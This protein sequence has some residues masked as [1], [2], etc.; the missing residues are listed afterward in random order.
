MIPEVNLKDDLGK[1]KTTVHL[2]DKDGTLTVYQLWKN[3][4][5]KTE[6]TAMRKKTKTGD[7]KVRA[8]ALSR[9]CP[10][11]GEYLVNDDGRIVYAVKGQKV[12]MKF[13]APKTQVM[14]IIINGLL[15][16][17]SELDHGADRGFHRRDSGAVR[18]VVAWPSRSAC[19]CRCSIRCRSSV[20]GL[21]RWGDRCLGAAQECR[22]R[23]R[24]HR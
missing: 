23:G 1:L 10:E 6:E 15:E 12:G 22:G 19:M 13:E 2:A 16:Q 14:G 5:P 11:E 4:K 3:D 18:R 8:A 20:G 17:E 7:E 21:V 9:G 24:G